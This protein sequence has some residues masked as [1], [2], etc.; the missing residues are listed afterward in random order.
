[1]VTANRW[2]KEDC[3]LAR[4]I[5]EETIPM[6]PEI[7]GGSAPAT[8][9]H[10]Y[11]LGN[12]AFPQETIDKGITQAQKALAIDSKSSSGHR[13]L[14]ALYGTKRE[15]D[16]AHAEGEMAVTLGLVIQH[17]PYAESLS[18]ARASGK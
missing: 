14:C 18:F 8:D 16:K 4:Q 1:M 10:D 7:P 15:Y 12:T 13:L 3:N 6:C 17:L 11:F 5:L 2:S 9:L